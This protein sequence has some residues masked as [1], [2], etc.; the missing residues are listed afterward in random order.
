M[1]AMVTFK[2]DEDPITREGAIIRT[3]TVQK[4]YS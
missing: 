2:F 4:P 1:V 3:T